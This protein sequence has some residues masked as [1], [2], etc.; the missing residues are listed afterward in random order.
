MQI[1]SDFTSSS[2]GSDKKIFRGC[3]ALTFLRF[4]FR[5]DKINFFR[6]FYMKV[7]GLDVIIWFFIIILLLI[8]HILTSFVVRANGRV[9]DLGLRL[10]GSGSDPRENRIHFPVFCLLYSRKVIIKF[11]TFNFLPY[12]YNQEEKTAI[13]YLFFILDPD[14]VIWMLRQD[15]NVW[16]KLSLVKTYSLFLC[17][18]KPFTHRGRGL[19]SNPNPGGFFPLLKKSLSNYQT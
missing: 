4:F 17:N 6:F 10:T 2:S 12:T 1:F 8:F 3:L 16:P 18:S 7:W 19:E 15:P 11:E 5:K 13:G 9:A 14:P